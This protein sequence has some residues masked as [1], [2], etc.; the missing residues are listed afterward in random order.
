MNWGWMCLLGI[1]MILGGALAWII[2][3][4]SVV[5]P[6]DISFLGMLPSVLNEANPLVLQ[7]MS[8][9]RVTLAG[10]MISIGVIYYQLA[11][12]GLRSGLHWT[13]T[14]LLTSA[15]VGFSSF[16]YIWAMAIL[17]R[18]MRQRR[19]SCSRCLCCPCVVIGSRLLGKTELDQ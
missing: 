11:R 4:T 9:D 7:F 13:R 17:I 16:F 19:L 2:A 1:G 14:A 5:L 6:Y 18:F 15:A 10:T 8:H 3:A 12:Y